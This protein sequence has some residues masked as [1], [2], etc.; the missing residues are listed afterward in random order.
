MRWEKILFDIV[1]NLAIAGCE[2]P[3]QKFNPEPKPLIFPTTLTAP[4]EKYRIRVS[5]GKITDEEIQRSKHHGGFFS[6]GGAVPSPDG[7]T[8]KTK[9]KMGKGP[10]SLKHNRKRR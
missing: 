10:S 6:S 2:F 3:Y 5:V 1:E 9:W 7:P 4:T 8:L